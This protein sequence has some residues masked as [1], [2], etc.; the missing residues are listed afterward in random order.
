MIDRYQSTIDSPIFPTLS[1]AS[2]NELRELLQA[3]IDKQTKAEKQ[4]IIR[5]LLNYMQEL[6]KDSDI[7]LSLLVTHDSDKTIGVREY[8]PPVEEDD[9]DEEDEGW[10]ME[11]NNI[12]V[13]DMFEGLEEE[14]ATEEETAEVEPQRKKK[15][16]SVGIIVKFKDG[17]VIHEKKAV[18][19]WLNALRKIGLDVIC[20]NS[21]RHEAWHNVDGKDVC[22]V[23]RVQTFRE[24]TGESPQS[25]V[26]GYYV[27][28]QLSNSQKI[29][30]LNALGR[31]LPKLGI[32]V[33]WVSEEGDSTDVETPTIEAPNNA[34]HQY[35]RTKYILNGSKPLNKRRFAHALVKKYVEDH[36]EVDYEGLK[37]VF[38]P[39]IISGRGVVRSITDLDD[40]RPEE[41]PK[42]YLMKDDELIYL[43]QSDDIITVCSQWNPD[44]IA[45]MIEIAR[46]IGY[47]VEEVGNETLDGDGSIHPMILPH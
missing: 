5:S 21:R 2:Q 9:E 27:M 28:T 14:S 1:E 43:P 32:K 34:S 40:I 10:V 46:S 23:E 25:L 11:S 26:D 19:T 44:R 8:Y 33:E 37:R 13:P 15:K 3:E 17:T 36:Q 30:D 16:K 18:H 31:F 6:M 42:R 35:D 4:E 7:E 22:I 12:G 47:S 41:Q 24:D 20:N 45:P 29:K 38:R 39:E